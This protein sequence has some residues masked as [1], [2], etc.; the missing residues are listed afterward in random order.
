MQTTSG[1]VRR[2][3]WRSV[4]SLAY[5][6]PSTGTYK[7]SL[8]LTWQQLTEQHYRTYADIQEAA[9]QGACGIAILVVREAAGKTVLERAAKRG[10]FDFWVGD[11]EDTE[12]PLSGFDASGGFPNPGRLSAS[13]TGTDRR[14]P[15][16][17]AWQ[18]HDDARTAGSRKGEEAT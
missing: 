3:A 9:E 10:G 7:D 1:L 11:E 13:R 15:S 8:L 4:I 18:S 14:S 17:A 16:R 6:L 12:L 2:Y 5:P